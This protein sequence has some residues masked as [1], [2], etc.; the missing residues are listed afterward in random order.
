MVKGWG[1]SRKGRRERKR[2]R[3]RDVDGREV[4]NVD[5]GVERLDR[6]RETS[7]VREGG[8]WG[9][10]ERARKK[11]QPTESQRDVGGREVSGKQIKE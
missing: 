6:E 10:R 11:G 7:V 8:W 2:E 4:I 9:E 1:V 3:Q 5:K